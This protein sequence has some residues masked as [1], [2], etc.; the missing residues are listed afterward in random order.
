MVHPCNMESLYLSLYSYSNR[1]VFVYQVCSTNLTCACDTEGICFAPFVRY[2]L[3]SYKACEICPGSVVI[4]IQSICFWR[5]EQMKP[6]SYYRA[7]HIY[8]DFLLVWKFIALKRLTV[9]HKHARGRC[10]VGTHAVGG[11]HVSPA[12]WQ[13]D[14]KKVNCGVERA[15]H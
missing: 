10:H 5:R 12:R 8:D 14:N 4:W 15:G 7:I 13:L 9:T 2:V 6:V 3:L 11:A 1:I